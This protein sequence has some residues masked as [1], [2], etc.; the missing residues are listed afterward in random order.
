MQKPSY[1]PMGDIHG[2]DVE[3][4]F[5]FGSLVQFGHSK[6]KNPAALSVSDCSLDC[7]TT[8]GIPIYLTLASASPAGLYSS[9][10]LDRR[11]RRSLL[12]GRPAP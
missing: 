5:D 6:S 8:T 7:V 2:Y 10:G 12:A 9:A 3:Y 1:Q 11:M 4:R